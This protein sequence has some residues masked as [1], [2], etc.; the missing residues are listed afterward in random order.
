MTTFSNRLQQDVYEA[1]KKMGHPTTLFPAVID[2]ELMCFRNELHQ[3]EG[4]ELEKAMG[5]GDLAAIADGIADLI[6]VL[7]GTAVC[8]GIDMQPVW[9]EVHRANMAKQPNTEGKFIK[10][11]GWNPPQIHRIIKEQSL[12]ATKGCE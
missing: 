2:D 8:Y 12:K 10:P 6:Y 4:E 3:E 5:E 9:D 11:P 1:H 7:M